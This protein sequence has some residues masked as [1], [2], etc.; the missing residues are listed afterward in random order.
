MSVDA[1]I[2][3]GLT[4]IDQQLPELEALE[5]YDD[6]ERGLRRDARRRRVI[7]A[8]AA[9]AAVVLAG[10]ASA[11]LLHAKHQV[12][13]VKKPRLEVTSTLDGL[14]ALPH[15][16]HWQTFPNLKAGITEVD[17]FIDGEKDWVEHEPPY[18]Y[19]TDHGYLVTSFLQPGQHTFMVKVIGPKGQT[20][21]DTV[22][23]TVS[24]APTPPSALQGTWKGARPWL[25]T[26]VVSPEGWHMTVAGGGHPWA[27]VAYPASGIAEVQSW[28]AA[29]EKHH[30]STW[31]TSYLYGSLCYNRQGGPGGSKLW[32]SKDQSRYRWTMTGRHLRLTLVGGHPCRGLHHFLTGSWT[33]VP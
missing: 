31:D 9:A 25:T 11:A 29:G 2:R 18:F 15:R 33:K 5:A 8:A 7:I 14:G 20:A 17:Y 13:P 1:R 27:D 10:A 26:L 12:E 6:L 4:M 21:T 23:A 19:G 30:G 16:I 22:T 32:S 28:M 3:E 24:K